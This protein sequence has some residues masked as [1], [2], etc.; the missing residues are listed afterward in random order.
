MDRIR[1]LILLL[2]TCLTAVAS[3]QAN[4]NVQWG[5]SSVNETQV[6]RFSPNGENVLTIGG[7]QLRLWR[8]SNG[9]FLWSRGVSNL[10][11]AQFSADSSVVLASTTTDIRK[12]SAGSGVDTGAF[13]AEVGA[14]GYIAVTPGGTQVAATADGTTLSF[15][16]FTTGALIGSFPTSPGPSAPYVSFFKASDAQP[17]RVLVGTNGYAMDGTFWGSA[18]GAAGDSALPMHQVLNGKT[19]VLEGNAGSYTTLYELWNFSAPTVYKTFDVSTL[20]ITPRAMSGAMSSNRRVFCIA[21]NNAGNTAGF[22]GILDATNGGVLGNVATSTVGAAKSLAF[23]P[24]SDDFALVSQVGSTSTWRL[25]LF[26]LNAARTNATLQWSQFNLSVAP[27]TQSIS[28][29]ANASVANAPIWVTGSTA[30]P[31]GSIGSQVF[32]GNTGARNR[33][34]SQTLYTGT[35]ARQL[36]VSTDGKYLAM[37]LPGS[38]NNLRIYNLT[39]GSNF[40]YAGHVTGV[41]FMNGTDLVVDGPTK[42]RIS[43]AAVS[44]ISFTWSERGAILDPVVSPDG[45]KVAMMDSFTNE[46]IIFNATTGVGV[47]YANS[48]VL[49]DFGF[50][51]NNSMWRLVVNNSGASNSAKMSVYSIGVSTMTLLR[52]KTMT[53]SLLSGGGFTGWQAK[54]SPN[55][56]WAAFV[57]TRTTSTGEFVNTVRFWRWSDSSL[58]EYELPISGSVGSVAFDLT[59]SM[60]RVGTSNGSVVSLNVPATVVLTVNPTTINGGVNATG[61]VTISEPGQMGGTVVNLTSTSNL[62]VPSTV[63][64]AEGATQTNFTV[65]SSGVAATVAESVSAKLSGLTSTVAMTINPATLKSLKFTPASVEG[66]ED[67][68]LTVS[69]NGKA[70]AGGAAIPITLNPWLI[71]P[72]ELTVPEGTASVTQIYGTKVVRIRQNGKATGTLNGSTKG[73]LVTIFEP[74][75]TALTLST[76]QVVGGESLT[77]TV[78]ISQLPPTNQGVIV[79]VVSDNGAATIVTPVRV[80]FGSMSKTF[81][82]NTTAVASDALVTISAMTSD[83]TTHSQQFTISAPTITNVTL[84]SGTI[85]AQGSTQGTVT[86][87]SPAPVGGYLVNL[88]GDDEGILL[89]DVTIPEGATSTAFGVSAAD[90][91]DDVSGLINAS[92][93]SSSASVSITI[94][95]RKITGVTL[96][97]GTRVGGQSTTGTVTI[98][99]AAP[100]GGYALAMSSDVTGVS[101]D[102]VTIPEGALSVNF[103]V[104]TVPIDA[105]STGM[106][107][108]THGTAMGATLTVTAPT[109]NGLGINKTTVTGG[110]TV[111]ITIYLTSAAPSGF[112]FNLA[113]NSAYATCPSSV[114]FVAGATSAEFIVNTTTPPN[115]VTAK[116]T[117]TRGAYSGAKS[118]KINP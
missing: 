98:N 43:G 104:T 3:T 113:S 95:G 19:F 28:G 36:A 27:I 47:R 65:K 29:P 87:S 68:E 37:V 101:V 22:V 76:N 35:R 61:T 82:I 5:A 72:T 17:L 66:G 41:A 14:K 81:T 16:N 6:V 45:T 115:Q 110:G 1:L 111:K 89:S 55:G 105:N 93:D 69:L 80:P 44:S 2:L 42:L 85:L 9:A 32:N 107:T 106:V 116:I 53:L 75:V 13:S 118:F 59:S 58:N 24:I 63:T 92:H 39:D 57:G 4:P 94:L 88:M 96:V 83:G 102:N 38:G 86:I 99:R 7:N 70:P 79:T 67:V 33:S 18:R 112:T 103:T 108:A 31:A 8:A 51:N 97:N 48:E 62:E 34:I 30:P 100:A 90:V 73:A 46:I 15:Y 64:V 40:L 91:Q 71:G 77:G 114:T 109:V 12:I 10:V 52:T 60:L 23:S 20:N 25:E 117:V 50:E 54:Q 56:K 84:D 74:K 49:A 78:T 26:R 21:G 11:D